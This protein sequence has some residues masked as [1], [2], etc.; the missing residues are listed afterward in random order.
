L[1]GSL[2]PITSE[3]CQSDYQRKVSK[4]TVIAGMTKEMCGKA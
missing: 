2:Q 4:L 3:K 1:R